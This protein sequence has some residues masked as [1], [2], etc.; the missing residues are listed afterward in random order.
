M[1]GC[2]R[3]VRMVP[4]SSLATTTAFSIF[5]SA[6]KRVWSI[7]KPWLST[8]WAKG[9]RADRTNER[10]AMTSRAAESFAGE[11]A[12]GETEVPELQTSRGANL[13]RSPS[14]SSVD[15]PPMSTTRIGVSKTGN[16]CR[17]PRWMR[18]RLFDARNDLDV[19]TGFVVERAHEVVAVLGFSHRARG[20]RPHRCAGDGGDLAHA[21][22]CGDASSHRVGAELLHVSRT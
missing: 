16:A 12:V 21:I 5:S 1:D 15:P 2:A 9:T 17:T 11:E 13:P 19:D 22:K 3:P 10:A 4:N 14:T 18:P 8:S 7:M 20:H 6:S